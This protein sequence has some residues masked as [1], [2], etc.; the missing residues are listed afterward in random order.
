MIRRYFMQALAALTGAA[1]LPKSDH[2]ADANNMVERE[3]TFTARTSGCGVM[4][5]WAT[6]RLDPASTRIYYTA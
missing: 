5:E 2:F 1:V 6:L 3:F 4:V